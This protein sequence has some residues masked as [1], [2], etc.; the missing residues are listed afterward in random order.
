MGCVD[1]H[2]TIATFELVKVEHCEHEF[3]HFH[4]I[5]GTGRHELEIEDCAGARLHV[6]SSKFAQMDTISGWIVCLVGFAGSDDEIH[7]WQGLQNSHVALIIPVWALSS[8]I[9]F[10]HSFE[11]QTFAADRIAWPG[12]DEVAC[13][14][15]SASTVNLGMVSWQPASLREHLPIFRD[16]FPLHVHRI[17]LF[18][19]APRMITPSKKLEAVKTTGFSLLSTE[20]GVECKIMPPS[21]RPATTLS[22]LLLLRAPHVSPGP[23][24]LVILRRLMFIQSSLILEKGHGVI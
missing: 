21:D 10:G 14:R 1:A 15:F 22:V 7:T 6:D 17:A 20:P 4:N 3:W 11:L 8:Q 16:G 24:F 5:H 13:E 18:Q 19:H 2:S 23:S 12:K 9:V